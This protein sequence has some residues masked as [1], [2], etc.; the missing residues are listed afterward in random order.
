[1]YY[2]Y[3][4]IYIYIDDSDRKIYMDRYVYHIFHIYNTIDI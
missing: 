2:I 3:I 1:M 4:Y